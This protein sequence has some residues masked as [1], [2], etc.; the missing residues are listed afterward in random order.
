MP[1]AKIC[2]DAT[3]AHFLRRNGELFCEKVAVTELAE[4]FGTPL[5]VYSAAA[6]RSRVRAIRVAFGERAHICFA[7]KS[8]SNLHV[9]RMLHAEGCGFDLVSGGELERL[10]AAEIPTARAVFAGVAKQQWEIEAA[11]AAQMLFVNVESRHELPMLSAAGESARRP[12]RVALRLNPD[13][14]AQTHA[15]ISTGK[16]ENKFGVSLG[17]AGSVVSEILAD[18]WLELVG[19][20]V[21]LGSQLQ[22]AAPYQ[23]ALD[24]VLSFVDERSERSVGVRYYDLGGGFGS[25]SGDRAGCDVG[26]VA[27][28]LLPELE[29]RGWVAVVEPG[30]YIVGDAGILVTAVL[31]DKVHARGGFQL[32]DAAMNDLLRPALYNAAH[33]IVP[34]VERAGVDEQLV[35]VVGPICES[36]DFLG[37]ERVLPRMEPGELLAVLSAGAYGASMASNYNT[38]RRPAEVLVDGFEAALVRRRETFQRMFADELEARS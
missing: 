18:P 37:R 9:L 29:R 15:F 35:D 5:Y 32:V 14:D 36:A 10:R 1:R 23:R 28:I 31:G 19:Y 17:H 27:D 25:A 30:R 21:H 26:A 13:V 4:R 38:R 34:V 7:V 8:N 3:A 24:R 2:P 12:V 11:V 16:A 33:P 6:M 22:S 20:Q